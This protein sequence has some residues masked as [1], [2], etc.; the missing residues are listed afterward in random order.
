MRN[1]DNYKSENIIFSFSWN[2]F[3]SVLIG[4]ITGISC[5]FFLKNNAK[6][7][8]NKNVD[9]FENKEA[10]IMFLIPW[11]CYLVSDVIKLAN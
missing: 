6:K 11:V 2:F 1:D 9:T 5:A 7:T 4:M 8:A 10:S 3:G